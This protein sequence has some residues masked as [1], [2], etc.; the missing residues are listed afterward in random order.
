MNQSDEIGL[1]SRVR[2]VEG[3][4]SGELDGET[5]LMS[6]DKGRYYGMD[7]IGSRIWKLIEHPI[8]VSDL[9]E[10]LCKEF[11]VSAEECERDTLNFLNQL[12][13]ASLLRAG[14]ETTG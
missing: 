10:Q 3:L 9:C 14:D 5:I 12:A 2:R 4:F 11:K 8:V 7:S 6:I 13:Q 1:S